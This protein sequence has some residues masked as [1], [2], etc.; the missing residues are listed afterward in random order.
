MRLHTRVEHAG[1]R[2]LPRVFVQW[3]I[4]PLRGREVRIR[5]RH[6]IA[7]DS[8]LLR[9]SL[10]IAS[11]PQLRYPIAM[12]VACLLAAASGCSRDSSTRVKI[13][14][15][16][17]HGGRATSSAV[18]KAEILRCPSAGI[19]TLQASSTTGHHR[20]ILSWNASAPTIRSED[21]AVGYCLYRSTMKSA[22]KQ[23][24]T[25]SKC[26]Q[27]NSVPISSTGCIDDL[28]TDGAAYYYVVTAIGAQG[29][30]STSSNEVPVFIPDANR[31][32]NSTSVSSF[33]SC[34]N[35]PI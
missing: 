10:N 9:Y 6:V 8:R 11:N 32:A 26:E 31:K 12:A 14:L 2:A 24:A 19:S 7:F 16:D 13:R 18:P 35:N 33:P 1:R 25:C 20:V 21:R 30:T 28:V 4:H 17:P 5:Y 23:N 22:A 34:R 29:K 27:I 3:R 15:T